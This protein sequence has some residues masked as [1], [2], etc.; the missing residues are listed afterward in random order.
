MATSHA[1]AWFR[2]SAGET[3]GGPGIQDHLGACLEVCQHITDTAQAREWAR[4][5]AGWQ[6]LPLRAVKH[7]PKPRRL[8]R[9]RW[10][11]G[12]EACPDPLPQPD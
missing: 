5:I 7:M 12:T 3:S 10:S 9:V 1:G 4:T 2:H 6:P 11:E 8:R